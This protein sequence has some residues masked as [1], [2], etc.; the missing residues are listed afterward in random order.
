M[1]H[2][3][4]SLRP[5]LRFRLLSLH[6]FIVCD[7]NLYSVSYYLKKNINFISFKVGTHYL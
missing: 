7:N 5:N 1:T 3:N 6:F 4:L 2:E